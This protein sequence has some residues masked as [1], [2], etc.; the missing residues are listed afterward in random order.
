VVLEDERP[1]G[2]V[3]RS[4][5]HLEGSGVDVD[6]GRDASNGWVNLS[7]ALRRDDG[8]EC[9][10]INFV[11]GYVSEAGIDYHVAGI[12]CSANPFYHCRNGV[13]PLQPC[14]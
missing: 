5:R 4:Q 1:G 2:G 9:G 12:T 13:G 14:S 6:D 7:L 3:L 8:M 11:G 10:W